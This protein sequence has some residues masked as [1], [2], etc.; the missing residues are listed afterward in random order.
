MKRLILF[1]LGLL[2]LASGC[3]YTF[4]PNLPEG[5]E[6]VAVPVIEN[7]TYRFGIEQE[8]TTA[9]IE[10]LL[11]NS[12]LTVT[13]EVNA[14]ALLDITIT[15]YY[16]RAVSY[17]ADESVKQR[18]LKVTL[19]VVFRDLAAKKD[20]WH[21]SALSERVLYHDENTAGYTAETEEQAFTRLVD[22]LAER[23]IN[24]IVEGW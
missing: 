11:T 8:L 14:D 15:S 13:S 2:L 1:L 21:D 7:N 17:D 5:I 20:L 10:E 12:P 24:R 9:V 23:L 18:E 4:S 19:E 6:T 16:T 22:L 3:Y